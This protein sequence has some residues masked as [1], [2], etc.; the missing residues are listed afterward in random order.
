MMQLVVDVGNTETVV[1]L[2]DGAALSA[3][4][5]LSTGVP[6]TP[7]EYRHLLAAFRK[8]EPVQQFLSRSS[9]DRLLTS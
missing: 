6:R 2:M 4:W 7:D 3:H 8:S 5:R 1:G 9:E